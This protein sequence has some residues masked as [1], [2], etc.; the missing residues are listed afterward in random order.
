MAAPM[1][2][3]RDTR[4]ATTVSDSP[5]I[6][7]GIDDSPGARA[8]ARTAAKLSEGLG[9]PLQLVHVARVTAPGHLTAYSAQASE[10]EQLREGARLLRDVAEEFELRAEHR[11]DVG[12]PTERLAQIAEDER[13]P[14]SSSARAGTARSRQPCSKASRAG[15]AG[16]CR[17]LSSWCR[18]GL[19]MAAVAA[20]RE[21]AGARLPA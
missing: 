1:A 8:A 10:D 6:L 14:C 13:A 12:E 19:R 2:A 11:L 21:R 15:L 5:R 4:Q 18:R 16:G 20:G 3:A 9:L 7:C 17:A